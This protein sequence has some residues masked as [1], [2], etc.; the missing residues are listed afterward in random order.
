MYIFKLTAKSNSGKIK[1]GM[2][3]Q[4]AESSS[5]PQ[6]STIKLAFLQQ[7]GIDAGSVSASNFIVEKIK[8]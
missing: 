8:M 6:L 5:S 4:V 7:W 2:S 1:A 3:I